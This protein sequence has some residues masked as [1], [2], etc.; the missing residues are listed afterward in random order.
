[1][2]DSVEDFYLSTAERT[3]AAARRVS[4]NLHVARDATHDAY[5]VM[6]DRWA[7]RMN[8]SLADNQRYVI[9]I[10]VKKVADWYRAHGR[11]VALPED[12]DPPAVD[13]SYDDVLDQLSLCKEVRRFLEDRPVVS[14]TVGILYFL[15]DF[16]QAEIAE[17]IGIDA[18]TVR[19]HVYRLR[20]QLRPMVERIS[21][22][23][24]RR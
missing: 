18:S 11:F 1:M 13:H 4:G 17:I 5:V 9:G 14:R 24:E 16:P 19:T 20:K 6:L 12:D 3:F 22:L 7:E 23:D 21:K 8:C 15:E 2:T 10:A